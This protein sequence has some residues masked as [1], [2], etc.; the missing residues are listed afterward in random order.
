MSAPGLPRRPGSVPP[1]FDVVGFGFNTDDHVCV[2]PRPPR[3]DAKLRLREY[4]RMPGGQVP[5]ALVALQRWGLRTAYVGPFG[6]DEGGRRQRAAL[7]ADGVDVSGCRTRTGIGSQTS[8]ILV[9]EVS[10]ERTVLWTRPPGLAFSA[11]ELDRTALGNGRAV[12]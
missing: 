9:D 6:D 2:V 11:A 12:L 1:A 8:I 5:T 10:G 4:A 7:A 3:V